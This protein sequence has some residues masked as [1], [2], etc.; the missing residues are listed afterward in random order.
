MTS[1]LEQIFPLFSSHIWKEKFFF[2]TTQFFL[3]FFLS[4]FFLLTFLKLNNE[5]EVIVQFF[6][7]SFQ[8]SNT[9]LVCYGLVR[10]SIVP[11]LF[12]IFVLWYFHLLVSYYPVNVLLLV[13][14]T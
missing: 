8:N 9:P 12:V 10:V 14:P 2:I 11:L 1:N 7:L 5:N 3:A 13:A 4:I 6:F